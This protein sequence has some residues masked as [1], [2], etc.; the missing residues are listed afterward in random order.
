[1]KTRSLLQSKGVAG[2]LVLAGGL[3]VAWVVGQSGR[4]VLAQ[5]SQAG[6]AAGRAVAQGL[7]SATGQDVARVVA[8]QIS[9][10]ADSKLNAGSPVKTDRRTVALSR[11]ETGWRLVKES[12]FQG[13]MLAFTEATELFPDDASFLVGLGLCQHRL[14][15]MILQ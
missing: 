3:G 14:L 5:P 4:I 15:G 8:E 13:A 2:L 7:Q 10:R 1:M 9:A 12:E 11:A 6:L